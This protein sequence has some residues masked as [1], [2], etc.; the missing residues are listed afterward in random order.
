[1]SNTCSQC[2]SIITCT[3]FVTCSCKLAIHFKCLNAHNSLPYNWITSSAV[4]KHV[5]SVLKSPSFIFSCHTCLQKHSLIPSPTIPPLSTTMTDLLNTIPFL[6]KD[7]S[8][9]LDQQDL[10]LLNISSQLKNNKPNYK[11]SPNIPVTHSIPLLPPSPPLPPSSIPLPPPPPPPTHIPSLLEL[12]INMH[13]RPV[14]NPSS[15][16]NHYSPNHPSPFSV[17][18]EHI[19]PSEKSREFLLELLTYINI[20][21]H[22][23]KSYNFSNA[24]VIIFFNT[25]SQCSYF[26]SKIPFIRSNSIYNHLYIRAER[27][28][29]ERTRGRVLFHATKSNLAPSNVK[30]T[31]NNFT[32]SFELRYFTNSNIDWNNNPVYISNDT[33]NTWSTSY[34]T[35]KL[36][37]KSLNS[38]IS[39][40]QSSHQSAQ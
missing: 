14:P 13:F 36:H 18:I 2:N 23:L 12:P 16:T 9:R 5:V 30:C 11:Y 3:N 15:T 8:T 29:T 7:I 35:Y 24:T 21:T 38:S 25:P 33:Y 26:Y 6:I 37:I 19:K 32:N 40:S 17:V 1:M 22:A 27:S 4:L 10:S 28:N 20:P 39:D 31:F 34:N